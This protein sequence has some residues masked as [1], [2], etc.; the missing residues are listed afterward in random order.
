LATTSLAKASIASGAKPL[1][2]EGGAAGTLDRQDGE[3]GDGHEG[4][5]RPIVDRPLVGP[6][7]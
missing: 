1:V 5:Q 6:A 3:A 4:R 7:E 2:A